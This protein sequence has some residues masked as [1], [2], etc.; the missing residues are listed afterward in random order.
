MSPDLALAIPC[1]NEAR[2]IRA[3]IEEFRACLPEASI[4]VFDNDSTDASAEI[5]RAAGARVVLVP[6]RGKGAVI[7]AMFR[8]IDADVLLMV[9]GDQTYPAERARDL[10]R[11]IAEGRAEMVVGS[12]LGLHGP[13]SFRRLHLFGNRLVLMTINSLFGAKLTDVLSGYRAFSRRFFKTVPAL[14]RGFEIETEITLHALDHHVPVVEVPVA[15]RARPAGS[16]SKL[17]TI[18]DGYRVLWAILRLYKDY[19]PLSFFGFAGAMLL[20]A[21]GLLGVAVV[22]EFLELGRVA[23]VARAALAVSACLAG[24]VAVA[25][26]LILETV[27]RRARELYVL[28]ADQL[29]APSRAQRRRQEP[30]P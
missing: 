15:Y 5:A 20:L 6:V 30:P 11:P 23:G 9:D 10:L 3:V 25:T 24:M 28:L 12:R 19:R 26:G 4:Y 21:G 2:T 7:R 22:R 16:E 14:S 18:R 8:E 13:G 29:I 17:R 1:F 27:N